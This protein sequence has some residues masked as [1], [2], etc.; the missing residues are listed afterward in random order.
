MQN[1]GTAKTDAIAVGEP[2][3]AEG[4][5]GCAGLAGVSDPCLEGAPGGAQANLGL[6]C[7]Y[8]GSEM[9]IGRD[10]RGGSGRR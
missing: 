7:L 4:C 1:S 3:G 2:R 5:R 8:G 10:W 6:K 9:S